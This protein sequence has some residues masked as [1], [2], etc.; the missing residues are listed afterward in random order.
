MT[1]EIDL[2]KEGIYERIAD[3]NDENVLIAIKTLIDNLE[4]NR[5]DKSTSKE[6]FTSYIKEWVKNM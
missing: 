5:D 4:E 3:I 2:I 6:D 1:T